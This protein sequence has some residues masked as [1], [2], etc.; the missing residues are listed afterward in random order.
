MVKMLT[1]SRII[2]LGSKFN[3]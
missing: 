3:F 2:H 1:Q